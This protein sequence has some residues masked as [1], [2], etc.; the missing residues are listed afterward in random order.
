MAVLMNSACA[1]DDNKLAIAA[2]GAVGQVVEVMDAHALDPGVQARACG[3][4]CNLAAEQTTEAKDER[5][6]V[7]I[8]SAGA[9][10]R[11]AGAMEAHATSRCSVAASNE[12][13]NRKSQAPAS[14]CRGWSRHD[15]PYRTVPEVGARSVGRRFVL[16]NHPW[17]PDS[18]SAF[19]RPDRRVITGNS[20]QQRPPPVFAPK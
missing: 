3:L 6:Q 15:L 12:S 2:A 10:S 16:S 13:D 11:I 8:A 5:L 20:V 4:F 9:V 17:T 18:I 19:L 1:H 7:R 14:E